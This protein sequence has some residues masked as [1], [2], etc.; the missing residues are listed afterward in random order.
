MI[1]YLI[2][3]IYLKPFKFHYL[4]YN[5]FFRIN[6][7]DILYIQKEAVDLKIGTKF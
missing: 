7:L 4:I 5:F 3:K 2:K 6:D 1:Y